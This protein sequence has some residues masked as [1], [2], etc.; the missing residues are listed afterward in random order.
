ML[1]KILPATI[2]NTYRGNRV[3]LIVFYLLTFIT[4]VRSCIHIFK[5]DGGA[6]S[7]A[8]IPLD[9]FTHGGAA[10]VILIFAYWGLSQ[11]LFGLLAVIVAL[12][13]K[14]LVPLMYAFF[15]AEYVGRFA[16]SI[17]KSIETTGTAPGGVINYILPPLLLVMLL[18]ATRQRN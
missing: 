3:A 17:F 2:D 8:T 16:I 7:I 11:L 5:F 18:L 13:Y 12:R 4:V 10:V 9:T 15:I 1:D 14:S 6:Q